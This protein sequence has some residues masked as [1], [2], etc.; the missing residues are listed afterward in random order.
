MSSSIARLIILLRVCGGNKRDSCIHFSHVF[1][2]MSVGGALAATFPNN[3]YF[4]SI[5]NVCYVDTATG[6]LAFTGEDNSF[7]IRS[8]RSQ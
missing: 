5:L 1:A 4:A 6:G 3:M 8:G 2:D 7:R